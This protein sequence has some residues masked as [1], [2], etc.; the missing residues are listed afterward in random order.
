MHSDVVTTP[1]PVAYTVSAINLAGKGTAYA[2]VT[3]RG[4]PLYTFSD[5]HAAVEEAAILNQSPTAPSPRAR[6]PRLR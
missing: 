4:V 2:V 1:R 3:P 6:D 5:K